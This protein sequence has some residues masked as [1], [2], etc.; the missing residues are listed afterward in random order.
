MRA[1]QT[2]CG[3]EKGTI[4][5][6]ELAVAFGDDPNPRYSSNAW[7]RLRAVETADLVRTIMPSP[8]AKY[9]CRDRC[10]QLVQEIGTWNT[11][12][13]QKNAALQVG[14]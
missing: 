1:K 9:V 7:K 4:S 2:C 13:W 11:W 6:F 3:S 10:A 5:L 12:N 8:R 14:I